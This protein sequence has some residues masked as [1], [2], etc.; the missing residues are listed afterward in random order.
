MLRVAMAGKWHVHAEGYAKRFNEQQDACVV[1]VWDDDEARGQSWAKELNVPFYKSFEDMLEKEIFDAVCVCCATNRHKEIMLKA[2]RAKKHIFTEKVMCLTEK[3]CKEVEREINENGV[4]FTISFPHRCFPQ[5]LYIKNA[6]DSGILGDIT[7]L[8]VRNCHD[9]A[10]K[11][12][13]PEYWYDP[14][15][16]GGGAMMDLGAHPMYLANWFLGKPKSVFSSFHRITRRQ[17]DDDALCVLEFEN[18]AR[19]LVETSLIAPNNPQICE[20]YGTKGVI[21]CE[22][23]K[24]RIRTTG[25]D[26]WIEPELPDPLDEPLRQFVDS[27]L[28]SKPIRFGTEQARA[29]SMMMEKA[30]QSADKG[31]KAAFE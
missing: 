9:G 15:T 21:L 3:D 8:R 30:Y 29:L 10:L 26:G 28:Y 13:L 7:L 20:V 2:A 24:V 5:N 1:C 25:S 23:S 19:A 16:T 6:I 31:E 18:G 11:G 4:K 17:V 22:N 14:V 12:W 27:V